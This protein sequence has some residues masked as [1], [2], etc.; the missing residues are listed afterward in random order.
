MHWSAATS[1]RDEGTADPASDAALARRVQL[2]DREAFECLAR[3]YLR[4]VH[5]VAASFLQE[6]PDVEDAA[7]E[8]FLRALE[9]IRDFDTKRPFAPWLY[10]I[11]RNVSRNHLKW[12][13][14][15]PT[16]SMVAVEERVAAAD[17]S[18][19]AGVE[20]SELR[21]ILSAAIAELPERRRTAFRLVDIEGFPATEAARLMGL[22][23]GAVRAH[24]HHARRV[25]RGALAPLLKDGG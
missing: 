4:A 20:Q 16:E 12:K 13:R 7:Q 2:G 23:P 5:A 3:R 8:T 21:E 17:P 19:A 22:T 11:A 6:R 1:G 10:Q 18:P 15:H 9:A 25:L 24:V 14:R